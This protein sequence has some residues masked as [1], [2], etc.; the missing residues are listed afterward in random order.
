MGCLAFSIHGFCF[1]PTRTDQYT[2]NLAKHKIMMSECSKLVRI[3]FPASSRNE[4]DIAFVATLH[5]LVYTECYIKGNCWLLT[6]IWHQHSFLFFRSPVLLRYCEISLTGNKPL[7]PTLTQIKNICA[8]T[9]SRDGSTTSPITGP[10]NSSSSKS[11]HSLGHH[12]QTDHKSTPKRKFNVSRRRSED[13]KKNKK[14]S[15]AGEFKRKNSKNMSKSMQSLEAC[16]QSGM[17]DTS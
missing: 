12:E 6:S 17:C 14:E 4:F 3:A 5:P 2:S 13:N 11:K 15:E 10:R 1:S 7:F 16:D 8:P 9:E